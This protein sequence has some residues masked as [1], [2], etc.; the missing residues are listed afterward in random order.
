MKKQLKL[1]DLQKSYGKDLKKVNNGKN[2][3]TGIYYYQP[4]KKR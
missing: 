3:N 4:N 1:T 2:N